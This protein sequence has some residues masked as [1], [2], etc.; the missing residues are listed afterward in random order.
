[1]S[2]L[3]ATPRTRGVAALERFAGP[4]Q[5]INHLRHPVARH[6]AV[7]L[8]G[9]LDEAGVVVQRLQLPRKIAGIEGVAVQ[10]VCACQQKTVNITSFAYILCQLGQ[11]RFDLIERDIALFGLCID[12]EQVADF[13]GGIERVDHAEAATLAGLHIAA[14][15]ADLPHL[16]H[17]TRNRITGRG[18]LL[19][20][21]N[22]CP[23]PF[24]QASS[25][26]VILDSHI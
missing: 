13:F 18:I 15:P 24:G 3:Y 6:V 12:M 11:Q 8:A 17:K 10:L 20:N 23:R 22:L 14:R 16:V 2:L 26:Q 19:E 9:Q 4:I 7:D 5:H 21:C 1:M 25:L